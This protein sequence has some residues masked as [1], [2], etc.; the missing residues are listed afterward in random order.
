MVYHQGMDRKYYRSMRKEIG[1]HPDR[2]IVQ[3]LSPWTRRYSAM[4]PVCQ[5]PDRLEI[6]R[7]QLDEQQPQEM[8]DQD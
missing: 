5:L 6:Q 3:K 2:A 8:E 4:Q 1:T 7:C